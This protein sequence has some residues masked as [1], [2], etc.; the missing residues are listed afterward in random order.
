[1]RDWMLIRL[2]AVPLFLLIVAAAASLLFFRFAERIRSSTTLTGFAPI[3][4]SLEFYV[5]G[6]LLIVAAGTAVYQTL[7]L[8]RWHQGKD[9]LCPQCGGMVT[10]QYG[11]R[12][13]Y[14][15]CLAC[16]VNSK[17]CARG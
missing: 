9:E 8:W 4:E 7:R 13:P 15:R 12:G 3:A 5:V 17:E 11:R 2:Y 16:G 10:H 6:G 1:M 14:R